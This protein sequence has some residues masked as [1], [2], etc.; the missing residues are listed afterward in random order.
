M[1]ALGLNQQGH[2]HCP[3][4]TAIKHTVL[5]PLY[6]KFSVA[7]YNIHGVDVTPD[8]FHQFMTGF[9]PLPQVLN[10]QEFRP[11]A[12]SH[13]T[14][15][16]RLCRRWGYHLVSSTGR[17]VGAVAIMIHTSLCPSLPIMKEYVH[18]HLIS[19]DLPVHPDPLIGLVTFAC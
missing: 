7:T 17:G 11:S 10:L 14:D 8:R 15:F 3:T 12:T 9:N 16:Q 1:H 6:D 2:T 5:P 18:G 4:N 19:V 13:V